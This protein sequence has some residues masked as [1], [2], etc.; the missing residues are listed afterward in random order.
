MKHGSRYEARS[1]TSGHRFSLLFV[2]LLATLIPCR[3]AEASPFGYYCFRVIARFAILVSVCAAKIHRN[4]LVLA[5]ALA[6]P[7]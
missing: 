5:R 1:A 3:Y 7:S 6:I 4:L 2:F